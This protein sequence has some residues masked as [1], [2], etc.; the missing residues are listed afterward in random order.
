MSYAAYLEIRLFVLIKRVR[1]IMEVME[2]KNKQYLLYET[3]PEFMDNILSLMD[4]IQTY[5]TTEKLTEE[6]LNYS[7]EGVT[8]VER[9]INLLD[10]L[11]LERE[12]PTYYRQYKE[13][14]KLVTLCETKF[15]TTT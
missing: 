3:M 1:I 2:L 15:T 8:F 9:I 13:V 5:I 6:M 11:Y 4:N 7:Y 10:T 14:N 12:K